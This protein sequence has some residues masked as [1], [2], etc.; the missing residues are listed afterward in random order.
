[1]TSSVGGG[2]SSAAVAKL[3]SAILPDQPLTA[4]APM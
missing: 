4:L 1:M 2:T 3:P